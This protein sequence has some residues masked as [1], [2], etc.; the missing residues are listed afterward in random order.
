[1]TG[2]PQ[3]IA[4]IMTRPERFG[5]IDAKE[6][7]SG[8]RQKRLLRL[9]VHFADEPDL[10]AVDLRFEPLLEVAPFAARQ[11][12]RDAKLHPCSARDADCTFRS[13]L[14]GQAPQEG[15]IGPFFV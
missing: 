4:S 7:R 3:A 10:C 11:L 12:G 2:V 6:Q 14:G 1:M 15:E 5:P 8:L 13:F 9:V